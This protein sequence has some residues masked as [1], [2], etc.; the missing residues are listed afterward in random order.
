MTTPAIIESDPPVSKTAPKK[1]RSG[2]IVVERPGVEPG[3]W[4]RWYR[5]G[6]GTP[7]PLDGKE[8]QPSKSRR[9]I[10]IPSGAL[11]SWPLWIS[12]EGDPGDLVRLELSGRH[13]LKKGMEESLNVLPV[14]QSEGR[15]LVLAIAAEQPFPEGTMPEGW[16]R[17]EGFEIQARL[18][19]DGKGGDLIVWKEH[20]TLF[21]SLYRDDHPV[22]FSP[23]TEGACGGVLKRTA[24]RLLSEGIIPRLP[25][26]LKLDRSLGAVRDGLIRELTAA[27]PHGRIIPMERE[28]SAPPFP[29]TP[30]LTMPP[31]EA[32][33]ERDRKKTRERLLLGAA[34]VGFL[35]FLL[36]IWG[37]G[38]L[39]LKKSAQRNLKRELDA[40]APVSEAARKAS[41]RWKA[42]RPAVD[43]SV[44]PLD[45]LSAVA[46]PT[47]GGKVRLTAFTVDHGKLQVS[48]EATDVSQAYAFIDQLKKN[49]LLRE[50]EWTTGQPQLAGKNSV[51]FDMEGIRPDESK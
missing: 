39:F 43:P 1:G 23:V 19:E 11:F 5:T 2:G 27:F 37:A 13:L 10:A 31:A 17:A 50:Y 35:Y 21:A 16:I 38:D 7:E 9:V 45:L 18:L 32:R 12:G 20:G 47:E 40:A 30:S 22:W 3:S 51:K 15:R 24:L 8:P 25:R 41:E 42:L 4:S 29:E 6:D 34:G 36:V 48:G 26:S 14:A 46:A 33:R 28:E 44:F 49:T